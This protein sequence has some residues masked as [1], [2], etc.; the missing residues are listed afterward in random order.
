M[1]GNDVLINSGIYEDIWDHEIDDEPIYCE[2]V[3][4]S[5]PEVLS[6][7]EK[8]DVIDPTLYKEEMEEVK[9]K[10]ENILSDKKQKP[11]ASMKKL[12]KS[13]ISQVDVFS[14]MHNKNP[15]YLFEAYK[16]KF[17]QPLYD[18]IFKNLI[19]I[20]EGDNVYKIAHELIVETRL[21]YSGYR[22]CKPVSV[23]KDKI[24][25]HIKSTMKAE[26]EKRKKHDVMKLLVKRA[27]ERGISLLI[28]EEKMVLEMDVKK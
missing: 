26:I 25:K 14:K 1:F 13:F 15:D 21:A 23:L 17:D 12:S 10:V 28:D 2:P 7:K 22:A 18:G 6:G 9:N 19:D 11:Q 5:K 16:L 3:K 4:Q 27:V 24:G 8:K 20:L